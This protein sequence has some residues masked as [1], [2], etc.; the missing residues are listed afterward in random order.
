MYG[1]GVQHPANLFHISGIPISLAHVQLKSAILILIVI[2]PTFSECSKLQC[3]RS[4]KS[5]EQ[6]RIKFSFTQIDQSK[7]VDSNEMLLQ[8]VKKKDS[9]TLASGALS[10]AR[11]LLVRLD[12]RLSPYPARVPRMLSF[13]S[14][15]ATYVRVASVRLAS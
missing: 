6:N 8:I 14:S 1:I 7:S 15:F 9:M 4:L 3:A 10:C 5:P 11:S 2:Q 13:F 12:F